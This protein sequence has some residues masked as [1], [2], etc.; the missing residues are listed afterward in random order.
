VEKEIILNQLWDLAERLA[1]Q[2]RRENL[3]GQAGGLCRLGEKWVFFIDNH[4]SQTE[5]IAQIAAGLASRDDLDDI[6]ILPQIRDVLEQ[7]RE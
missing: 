2:I 6:F 7:Y 5:Q 3:D 4:A 1:I